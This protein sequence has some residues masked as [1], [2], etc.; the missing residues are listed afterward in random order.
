MMNNT[1]FL[2]DIKNISK[3]KTKQAIFYKILGYF[4]N[5]IFIHIYSIITLTSFLYIFAKKYYYG[6]KINSLKLKI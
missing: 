4:T 5:L 1:F 6:E 2:N 3:P